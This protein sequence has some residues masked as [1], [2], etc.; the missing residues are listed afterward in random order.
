M[1][2]KYDLGDY[3]ITKDFRGTV[4][5]ITITKKGVRYRA[6]GEA[7]FDGGFRNGYQEDIWEDEIIF[8]RIEIES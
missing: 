4:S 1:K 7:K 3:I 2:T 6:Y 5:M 8:R